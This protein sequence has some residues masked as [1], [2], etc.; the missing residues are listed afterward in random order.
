MRIDEE[1]LLL[2]L[3]LLLRNCR[4]NL[5]HPCVDELL[6]LRHLLIC[7]LHLESLL[8][9]LLNLLRSLLRDLVLL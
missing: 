2:W 7:S 1:L 9:K 4:L 3:L 6:R 8:L 5:N